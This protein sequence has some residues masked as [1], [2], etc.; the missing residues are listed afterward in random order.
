LK[1]LRTDIFTFQGWNSFSLSIERYSVTALSVTNYYTILK[2]SGGH[3]KFEVVDITK[4][5]FYAK[6]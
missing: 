6:L 2:F 3:T 1:T 4:N 5:G